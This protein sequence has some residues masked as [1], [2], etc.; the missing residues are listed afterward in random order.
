MEEFEL[1]GG[2]QCGAVRYSLTEPPQMV[3]ACHCTIC[4]KISTSIF[5]IS[6]IIN[7]KSIEITRGELGQVEWTAD[8]GIK[9]FGEFCVNCGVRIR[10]GQ[11]NSL[12]IYVLR[13]GTI[14]N[15]LWARPAAHIWLS[16]A[17][18]WF[19]PPEEDLKYDVQPIDYDPIDSLYRERIE[20]QT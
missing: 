11:I 6:C 20:N 13:G 14:D 19:T 7:E 9:R 18:H 4:R 10:H 2:C 5:N 12:G 8:N 16:E 15:Q 3:Y 17:A 1:E